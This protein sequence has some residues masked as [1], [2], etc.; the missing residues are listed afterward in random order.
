MDHFFY[1]REDDPTVSLGTIP[2]L[3]S[4]TMQEFKSR[5][6]EEFGER[7]QCLAEMWKLH[8]ERPGTKEEAD[9][10]GNTLVQTA[11][12]EV[13]E[14][15]DSDVPRPLAGVD[16]DAVKLLIT[17]PAVGHRFKV[18]V[19]EEYN[20][21]WDYL[22][23]HTTNL[24]VTGQSGIGK[25]LFL[26]WALLKALNHRRPVVFANSAGGFYYFNNN[27]ATVRT[28]GSLQ[29]VPDGTLG[30]FEPPSDIKKHLSDVANL[31]IVLTCS[32]NLVHYKE[33]Q[34][35]MRAKIWPMDC[36]DQYFFIQRSE[37]ARPEHTLEQV[38]KCTIPTPYLRL[39]VAQF[40]ASAQEA[41]RLAMYK[42]MSPLGTTAG[43]VFETLALAWCTR[44]PLLCTLNED[45]LNFT[46]PPL[47]PSMLDE[48]S[49][50]HD[51]R[52]RLFLAPAGFPTIDAFAVIR[53]SAD[54]W[55][56]VIF[57]QVT[58]CRTHQMRGGGI[59]KAMRTL[60]NAS[61]P[62]TGVRLSF[63]FVVPNDDVGKTMVDMG[64]GYAVVAPHILTDSKQVTAAEVESRLLFDYPETAVTVSDEDGEASA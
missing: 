6:A 15:V 41:E 33:Y 46:L 36:F 1:Q 35:Q 19:R 12:D 39:R 23:G 11:I 61:E 50:L 22:A 63:V 10:L 38:T 2:H 57:L 62:P 4:Q 30:L 44:E 59:G 27:G 58:L 9:R 26:R 25:S 21:L 48:A 7:W 43:P 51:V 32:P 45:Q 29:A 56:H 34:K 64:V 60:F 53:D 17:L 42:A 37:A 28:A 14:P 5:V 31:A 13:A 52:N 20:R 8:E 3:P 54:G 40:I 18:I 16:R 47:N 24:V 49:P 55:P